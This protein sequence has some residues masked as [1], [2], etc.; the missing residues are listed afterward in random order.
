MRA[1]I[2]AVRKHFV[3]ALPEIPETVREKITNKER[4]AEVV[5]VAATAAAVL[6]LS[7]A[8]QLGLAQYTITGM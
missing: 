1:S 8:L 5:V 7:T 2:G 6:F 3:P 4:I